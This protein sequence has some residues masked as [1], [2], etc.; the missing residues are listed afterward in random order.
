MAHM[1][2]LDQNSLE[3]STGFWLALHPK[4]GSVIDHALS[5]SVPSS[6]ETFALLRLFLASKR[7]RVLCLH[8]S[9]FYH[10][11]QLGHGSQLT[12]IWYP[13]D[14]MLCATFSTDLIFMLEALIPELALCGLQLKSAKPKIFDN[15]SLGQV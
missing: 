10:G 14:L 7:E 15:I 4:R 9:S 13:D 2:S 1:K 12:H 8:S 6:C 11:V 3:H 5:R